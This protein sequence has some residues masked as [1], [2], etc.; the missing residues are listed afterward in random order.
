[1]KSCKICG[2]P[3]GDTVFLWVDDVTW[4]AMGLKSDDFLCAHCIV[5]RLSS[6]IT[7]AYVIRGEGTH[8]IKAAHATI[9]ME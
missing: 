1:M 5:D 4:K 7:A 2:K 3:W 8:Q 6:V 9:S